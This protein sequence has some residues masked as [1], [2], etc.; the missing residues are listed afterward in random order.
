[1]SSSGKAV[2]SNGVIEYDGVV[3]GSVANLTCN[4]GYT[5]GENSSIRTCMNNGKWSG[6]NQTCAFP[7]CK[8]NLLI[9]RMFYF[10]KSAM[11][12]GTTTRK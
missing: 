1:M 8:N 5:P 10:Q 3:V 11:G 2:T 12:L 6:M 4:E 9:D 7:H